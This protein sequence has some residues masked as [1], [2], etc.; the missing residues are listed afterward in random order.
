MEIMK[1]TEEKATNAYLKVRKNKT[2]AINYLIEGS[3]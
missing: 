1:E 2:R 3:L